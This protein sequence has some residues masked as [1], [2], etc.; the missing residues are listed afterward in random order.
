MKKN[1]CRHTYC[2]FTEVVKG[3]NPEGKEV[4]VVQSVNW[5]SKCKKRVVLKNNS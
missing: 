5:C 2:Y 3:V 1:S 4:L